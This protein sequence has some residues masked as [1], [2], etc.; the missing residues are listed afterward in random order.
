MS[1]EILLQ[2][3]LNNEFE[4]D[5]SKLSNEDKIR[6][7]QTINL[8]QGCLKSMNSFIFHVELMKRLKDLNKTIE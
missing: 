5:I 7:Q 3:Y 4:I 6:Y 8:L 2:R 1:I